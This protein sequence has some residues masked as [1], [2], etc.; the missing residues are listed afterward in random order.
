MIN[1]VA[2]SG[3]RW[4]LAWYFSAK[5]NIPFLNETVGNENKDN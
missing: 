5:L 3:Y 2:L 4:S 1:Y